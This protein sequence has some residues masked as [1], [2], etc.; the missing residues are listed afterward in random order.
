MSQTRRR[1]LAQST[2]A[3]VSATTAGIP[4]ASLGAVEPEPQRIDEDDLLF[5]LSHLS[6][7]D[8]DEFL[9]LLIEQGSLPADWVV[10]GDFLILPKKETGIKP[11]VLRA[12][13][14][15]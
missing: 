2:A 4:L 14:T 1:F 7:E 5:F 9:S 15:G 6:D 11:V 8:G 12:R 10:S 3:A 13:L